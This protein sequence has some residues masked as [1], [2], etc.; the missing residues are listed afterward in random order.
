MHG[1]ENC[2]ESTRVIMDICACTCMCGGVRVGDATKVIKEKLARNCRTRLSLLTVNESFDPVSPLHFFK[3]IITCVHQLISIIAV[4]RLSAPPSPAGLTSL[5]V[6]SRA[7]LTAAPPTTVLQMSAA[8][9]SLTRMY[10]F[11][12]LRT[13][14]TRAGK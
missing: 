3:G 13:C 5:V 8:G 12:V 7:G 1:K 9:G 4:P 11:W 14:G 10:C 6:L 2:C